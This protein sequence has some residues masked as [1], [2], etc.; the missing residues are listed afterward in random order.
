MSLSSVPL[1]F[2]VLA[3]ATVALVA[4]TG[5]RSA[6]ANE[7]AN[8]QGLITIS[9]PHVG[10]RSPACSELVVEARGALDNHLI[11]LTHAA[12]DADGNCRY[13]LTVPA[14]S[15]VWLHIRPALV[16]AAR[17]IAAGGELDPAAPR[18]A[19]A[20]G[21]PRERTTTASVGIRFTIVAPNT[22]FFA[23]G[24]QKAVPLSY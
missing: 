4:F 20:A 9:E 24:E 15:A 13:E 10:V 18:I 17:S 11:G 5:P 22:Y 2:S 12:T 16:Q 14:Q 3:S 23:P 19:N 21:A 6:T 8:A 1:R 7:L